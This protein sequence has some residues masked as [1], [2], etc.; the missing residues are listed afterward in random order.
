MGYE[1]PTISVNETA[2]FEDVGAPGPLVNWLS[3]FEETKVYASLPYWGL[4]N[5]MNEIA[6][7][8]NKPNGS[9]WLYKWYAEMQGHTLTLEKENIA[10]P[11]SYGS[12][13]GLTSLDDDN[14]TIKTLFGGQPGSQTMRISNITKTK[15][16]EN[17][18]KAHVKIYKTRYTGHHGFADDTPVVF[19]GN[20]DFIGDE[21]IYEIDDGDLMDA[22]HAIVTPAVE[23]AE[24]KNGLWGA[25]YEAENAT[26]VGGARAYTKTGGSDLARSNRAEVGSINNKTDGVEYTIEVPEDGVYRLDNFYSVQAPQV[27]PLTLKYVDK[28]GQ[29]RAIGS[30]LKHKMIIDG[31]KEFNL[32]YQSTVKWGYY[33]Y[34]TV[35]SELSKGQHSVKIMHND[36]DQSGKEVASQ[37]VAALDKLDVTKADEKCFETVTVQAEER[38]E[39]G[40]DFIFGHEG[41]GFNSGGYAVGTGNF[42]FY[43]NVPKDGYYDLTASVAG[44][45]IQMKKKVF[46][47]ATDAKAQSDIG[48][49]WTDLFDGSF[50]EVIEEKNLGK[51]YLTAGINQLCVS[52][53]EQVKLDQF[54]FSYDVE[55]TKTGGIILEAEAGKVTDNAFD[56]DYTYLPGSAEKPKIVENNYSSGGKVVEGFRGGKENTLTFEVNTATAGVYDLSL[57]YSNNEPAPVMKTDAGKNY[58]HPYNTDLVERYAQIKVN[59]GAAATV[60]FRNTL[61][62]DS[63]R[64]TIIK[65]ELK[66]GKNTINIGNDNSYKFS[67]VQD[68]FTPRFDKITL[69]PTVYTGSPAP[70]VKP[71][72]VEI[73]AKGIKT[74]KKGK[75]M[76]LLVSVNPPEA[77]QSIEWVIDNPKLVSIDENGQLKALKE[78]TTKV[79]AKTSN[80]KT[81]NFTIRVTK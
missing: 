11:S 50:G 74:L 45:T 66:Q 29:N 57:V 80:G 72:S 15:T 54:T 44:G 53:T 43:V 18:K 28:G 51:V 68:D 1:K 69:T 79:T 33:N 58:I 32:T 31:D 13:Y 37:L 73:N 20:V 59:D 61:S 39:S 9:W 42:N 38:T 2:N 47:Y 23:E 71:E 65:V 27:D 55:A 4:A 63:F 41:T 62:W 56:D 34:E 25:T 40:S 3:I 14:Q 19:E 67:S 75:T 76:E 7:D 16:F 36:K 48:S 35:Y 30:L 24:T 12:L 10:R 64:N 49:S 70:E 8:T 46:N 52:T 5:N 21:L 81:S 78:G 60:Y 77:D 6:A 22:F 26:M 17:A